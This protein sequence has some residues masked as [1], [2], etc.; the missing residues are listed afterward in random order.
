MQNQEHSKVIVTNFKMSFWSMVWFQFKWAMATIPTLI[1]IILLWGIL[2]VF[3]PA[4]FDGFV[5][6]FKSSFE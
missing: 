6:G 5:E 2:A 1:L 4:F 3:A